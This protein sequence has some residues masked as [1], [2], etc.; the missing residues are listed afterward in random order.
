MRVWK[1]GI[2]QGR[3]RERVV[4]RAKNCKY[5]LRL[6]SYLKEHNRKIENVKWKV[7]RESVREIIKKEGR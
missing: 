5:T 7:K 4:V 6:K 1:W 2:E 3:G